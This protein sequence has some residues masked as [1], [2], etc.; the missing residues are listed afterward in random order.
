MTIS[1]KMAR[2]LGMGVLLML[3]VAVSLFSYQVM[4]R[5]AST[6]TNAI[7]VE[8]EKVRVWYE[9]SRF[10]HESKYELQEYIH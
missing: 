2:T 7:I 6:L 4:S 9:I 8:Q 3:I 1:F 5:T 10:I